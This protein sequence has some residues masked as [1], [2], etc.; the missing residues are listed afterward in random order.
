[1]P[2]WDKILKEIE[3]LNPLTVLQQYINLLHNSTNRTTICY[4]SAFSVIKPP[5]PSPFHS[6][7]DQDIQGFMTCTNETDKTKLDLILHT[8][9][10]DYEATK[11][12]IN[13][14]HETYN[15]IRVFIPHMAMSGGTLIAC[16][17]DEIYMGPYSSLGPIDPQVF[18]NNNYVPVNAIIEEF[19]MAFEEVSKDPNKALLWN[20]RLKQ[21]PF[22]R[23]KAA[24]NMDEN[25]LKYIVDLLQKRNCKDSKVDV[26]Q[27]L[28][29]FLNSGKTHSSH[30]RGISL[31]DAI[32]NGLN[33]KDLREE[34]SLEDAV[35][36]I[37]HAAIILFEKTT[38]QKI[39]VNNLGKKYINNYSST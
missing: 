38:V 7:I 29:K 32:T 36:S 15:N 2:T 9:G 3:N 16:S 6:I 37:Y 5:V 30:G 27:K 26:I 23:M 31:K 20:E 22:G 14:L 33:V 17:A 1:M 19:E 24:Q 39:I 21:I 28:A 34:K 11:R 8:P 18:L 35:L 25:S 12:I 13:Y 10:G 4:M